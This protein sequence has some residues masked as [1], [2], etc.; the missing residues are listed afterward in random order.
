M[1]D[2]RGEYEERQPTVAVPDPGAESKVLIEALDAGIGI[3]QI[4]LIEQSKKNTGKKL[5][6]KQKKRGT[7][8]IVTPVTKLYFYFHHLLAVLG[9]NTNRSPV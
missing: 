1:H 4:G 2:N 8:K 7:T 3:L 5:Q 9:T 6:N